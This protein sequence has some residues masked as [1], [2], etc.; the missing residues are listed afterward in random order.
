ML[1]FSSSTPQD[2]A[3][4]GRFIWRKK[5]NFTIHEHASQ[6]VVEQ[7][8]REFI[9]EDGDPQLAL[10]RIFRLVDVDDLPPDVQELVDPNEQQVMALTGTWGTEEAWQHR[11]RSQ[12]HQ[13]VPFSAI[14]VPEKIPMFQEVMRQLGLDLEHFY[15][16]KELV[17]TSSRDYR[18]TFHILDC[19]S[20]AIP[21]QEEFVKPYGIKSLVGFG[22]F[23]GGVQT[24]YL[25]YAFSLVHV[26][27]EAAEMFYQLQDFIATTIAVQETIFES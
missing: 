13:A 12:G 11:S 19:R 18:G 24:L 17:A 2:Y 7:L 21:A 20:P 26:S 15:K 5:D 6:F 10:V 22:G 25:L 14:A 4:F 8:F 3:D 16:T 9:T 27:D 23:F 1:N